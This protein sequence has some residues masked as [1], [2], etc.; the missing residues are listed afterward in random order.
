MFVAL[1][2]TRDPPDYAYLN[3]AARTVGGA[4]RLGTLLWQSQVSKVTGDVLAYCMG[5]AKRKGRDSPLT[6]SL[7]AV[8]EILEE[9]E[10]GDT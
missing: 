8:Q 10:N 7:S 1:Y 5:I 4:G 9:C 3:K 2:P 6:S